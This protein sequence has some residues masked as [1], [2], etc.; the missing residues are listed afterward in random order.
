MTVY[1]DNARLSFGRMKMAH[2]L[3]TDLE[4][5][6]Q[7]ADKIGVARKWFQSK[8]STPHYDIC[9]SKRKLALELGAVE[10]DRHKVVEIIHYW[11]SHARPMPQM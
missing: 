4:E 5:L 9:L 7:M 11:R 1:V 3:S 2:L 6:H 10:A 8:A